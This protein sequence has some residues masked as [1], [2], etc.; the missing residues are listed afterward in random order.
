[1]QI[2]VI[3]SNK[4]IYKLIFK[5]TSSMTSLK[6]TLTLIKKQHIVKTKESTAY[7]IDNNRAETN[8]LIHYCFDNDSPYATSFLSTFQN[9]LND[10][11]DE[12]IEDYFYYYSPENIN[13][14]SDYLDIKEL[15]EKINKRIAELSK[16]TTNKDTNKIRVKS[17][18]QDLKDCKK[19]KNPINIKYLVIVLDNCICIQLKDKGKAIQQQ[20]SF[21]GITQ[22][23]F[24]VVKNAIILKP[25]FDAVIELEHNKLEHKIS[26]RQ[27]LDFGLF[28]AK[29]IIPD[30]HE[31]NELIAYIK[32]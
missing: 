23:E 22:K 24:R 18:Q 8:C 15:E 17:L 29:C 7:T 12:K 27:A 28:N 4:T 20:S 26:F 30:T 1:M 2:Y 21:M 5:D 10:K 16:K 31:P 6:D 9:I 11:H 13:N 14:E 3:S 19:S 25:F 32:G